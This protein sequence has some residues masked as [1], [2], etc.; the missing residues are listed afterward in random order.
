[1]FFDCIMH[2]L[3]L[4]SVRLCIGEYVCVFACL[5]LVLKMFK[6]DDLIEAFLVL[7]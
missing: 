3:C 4:D 2:D 5:V 1:M 6:S 7:V